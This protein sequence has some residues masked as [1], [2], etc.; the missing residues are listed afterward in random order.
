M[1]YISIDTKRVLNRSKGSSPYKC[2]YSISPY[3]GCEFKCVYCTRYHHNDHYDGPADK[4]RVE[5]NS[6]EVLKKE[7]KNMK[8]NVVCIWGYQPAE[9]IYRIIRKDLGVLRSRLYPV[10][11]LTRSPMVI[12]DLDTISKIS[13][14]S[15][16]CV[17]FFISSLDR[18]FVRNFETNAPDPMECLQTMDELKKVDIQTGIILSPIMPYITDSDEYL[19][20]IFMEAKNHKADYVIPKLLILEDAYRARVIQRIKKHYPKLVIK[21]KKLY[22]LGPHADVRYTRMIMRKIKKLTRKFNISDE[23]PTYSDDVKRE[24][25]NLDKFF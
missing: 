3:H 4:I 1:E 11:I 7:L 20:N 21:Y 10:H 12:E 16:C 6:S 23:I 5:I 25:L 9:K 15:W 14:E 8:K 13:K 17:S 2:N 19:Q 22:D 18:K 24:Q